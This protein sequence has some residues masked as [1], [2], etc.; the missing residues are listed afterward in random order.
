MLAADT[1]WLVYDQREALRGVPGTHALVI[2]ISIYRFLD[3]DTNEASVFKANGLQQLPVAARSAFIFHNWIL[4]HA[5][6]LAA[7]L[8]T[9][10]LLLAPSPAEADEIKC[11]QCQTDWGIEDVS[12]ALY[13]WRDDA[14]FNPADATI[15]YFCGHGFD[16][17]PSNPLIALGDLGAP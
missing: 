16:F 1:G 17:D 8:K 9:L 6:R 7:P 11:T 15:F 4:E 14:S 2:G 10:R 12:S 5:D 13:D 3:S